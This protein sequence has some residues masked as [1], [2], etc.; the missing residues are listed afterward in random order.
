M[1]RRKLLNSLAKKVQK[2]AKGIQIGDQIVQEENWTK[3]TEAFSLFLVK[4]LTEKE[5]QTLLQSLENKGGIHTDCIL[6]PEEDNLLKL[7]GLTKANLL[8]CKIL[9][10]PDLKRFSTLKSLIYCK[11]NDSRTCGNPYHYSRIILPERQLWKSRTDIS[12][13]N[14]GCCAP[15]LDRHR[16]LSWPPSGPPTTTTPT[17]TTTPSTSSWCSIAYWEVRKRVGRLFD[18][19]S[20]CTN[21]FY[22]LPQG[23]GLCV[24]LLESHPDRDEYVTKVR[25]HIGFGFQLTRERSGIWIYNRSDYCIFVGLP[26]LALQRQ[27]PGCRIEEE[28]NPSSLVP[29]QQQQPEVTKVP[30]GHCLR[31][32][33]F[34]HPVQRDVLERRNSYLASS[35]GRCD[36]FCIRVSFAK[37][38]GEKY[39]RQYITSCPCWVEVY[40]N[41]SCLA[42]ACDT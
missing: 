15:T 12:P 4:F 16:S 18:V 33:D 27:Y 32:V 5:L 9:R 17:T 13:S 22:E 3:L 14:E 20:N 11:N 40:L 21:V 8:F 37:G 36:L 39:T 42:V 29:V 31:V 41:D 7:T 38:W 34:T 6:I 23:D 35:L 24:R 28:S 1:F 25:N 2:Y 30:A 19:F 10:W 26:A